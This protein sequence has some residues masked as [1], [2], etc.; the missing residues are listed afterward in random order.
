M[1]N[2]SPNPNIAKPITSITK[3]IGFGRKVYVFVE[4]QNN[5][6]IDFTLKMSEINQ[7]NYPQNYYP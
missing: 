4:V 5:L 2:A 6:G 7:I 1:R 3:E